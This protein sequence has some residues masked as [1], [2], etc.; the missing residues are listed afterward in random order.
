MLS[1]QNLRFEGICRKFWSDTQ[2]TL[3]GQS[4][5]KWY[6]RVIKQGFHI[7]GPLQ[8]PM[9]RILKLV[10]GLSTLV[11]GQHCLVQHRC[12]RL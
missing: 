6:I 12:A 1:T 4:V 7:S 3:Y 11:C 2:S 5:C 9:V 10:W 8:G